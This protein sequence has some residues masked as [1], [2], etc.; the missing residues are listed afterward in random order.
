LF[1]ESRRRLLEGYKETAA[2]LFDDLRII[3]YNVITKR[4][5]PRPFLDGAAVCSTA[6]AVFLTGG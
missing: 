6:N 3:L 4:E 1:P 5:Q 2:N